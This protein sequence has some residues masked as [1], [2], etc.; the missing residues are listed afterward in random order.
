[1]LQALYNLLLSHVLRYQ[2]VSK[3]NSLEVGITIEVNQTS[4]IRN[5][6]MQYGHNMDIIKK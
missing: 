6:N 5:G 2:Q 4:Q 3:S 1:M